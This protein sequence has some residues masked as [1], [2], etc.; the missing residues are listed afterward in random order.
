MSVKQDRTTLIITYEISKAMKHLIEKTQYQNL[1]EVCNAAGIAQG[2]EAGTTRFQAAI[3]ISWLSAFILIF[4]QRLLYREEPF[5]FE[6]AGEKIIELD[7][8]NPVPEK[9]LRHIDNILFTV[10]FTLLSVMVAVIYFG[11]GKVTM[12]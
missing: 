1:E 11:Y 5:T 3:M 7:I 8:E 4:V 10:I 9:Y 12:G 6:L 2:I